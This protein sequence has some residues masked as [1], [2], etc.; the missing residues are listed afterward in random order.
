MIYQLYHQQ[1][2]IKVLT[3]L[4]GNF[5]YTYYRFYLIHLLFLNVRHTSKLKL[6]TIQPCLGKSSTLKLMMNYRSC[7]MIE[8]WVRFQWISIK[9][10][11]FYS[12]KRYNVDKY[13]QTDDSLYYKRGIVL[14]MLK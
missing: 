1:K 7:T 12:Y 6:A 2:T 9:N 13:K 11:G 8:R 14:L 10:K 4:I 3:L 5:L